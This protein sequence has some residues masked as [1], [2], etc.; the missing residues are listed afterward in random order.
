FSRDRQP[1]VVTHDGQILVYAGD[2]D[3]D[4]QEGQDLCVDYDME[5]LPAQTLRSK[6]PRKRKRTLGTGTRKE[7][8]IVDEHRSGTEDFTAP[9][10]VTK[11]RRRAATNDPSVNDGAPDVPLAARGDRRPNASSA[12]D[13]APRPVAP[14]PRREPSTRPEQTR[15]PGPLRRQLAPRDD[16]SDSDGCDVNELQRPAV[17]SYVPKPFSPLDLGPPIVA[18]ARKRLRVGTPPWPDRLEDSPV[19]PGGARPARSMSR[20]PSRAPKRKFEQDEEDMLPDVFPVDQRQFART[21]PRRDPSSY[22]QG[23]S[24]VVR[25]AHATR[26]EPERHGPL[27]ERSQGMGEPGRYPGSYPP[28]MGYLEPPQARLDRGYRQALQPERMPREFSGRQDLRPYGAHRARARSP[29]YEQDEGYYQYD[30]A[31]YDDAQY[32]EPQYDDRG[33]GQYR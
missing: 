33:H 21:P 4:T 31:Q 16:F 27:R 10:P 11:H 30:D 17:P 8:Y 9:K 20:L 13:V 28:R 15:A 32:D 12:P 25:I 19:A 26:H 29:Y 14:L 7:P 23:R 1:A 6:K 24:P 2:A 5:A 3:G 18:R 22:P